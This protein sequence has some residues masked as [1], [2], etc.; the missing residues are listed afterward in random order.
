METSTKSP[1]PHIGRKVARMREMLGIK[2]EAL[3]HDLGI[4]QQAVSKLEQSP[5][6]EEDRLEQVAK[7]LGVPAKAIENFSEETAINIISNTFH[8]QAVNMNYRCT[9]NPMDKMVELYD[10]LLK[11]KDEKIALLERF[12]AERQ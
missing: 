10:A 1:T 12:L 5:V 7:V 6:L 11:E 8:D 2:Q 4:T 3:A 9:F